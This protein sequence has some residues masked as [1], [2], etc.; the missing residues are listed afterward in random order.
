M[1]KSGIRLHVVAGVALLASSI[2]IGP[3]MAATDTKSF[4]D[5]FD[6]LASSRWYV[7]DGWANGAHQN[8]AWSK[9][10]IS[11][12]GGYL[13]VGFRKEPGADN[14]AYICGE[15]QTRTEFSYGT[16]EARYKTPAGS[17]LN[18]AFFTYIAPPKAAAHDEI[19]FEGLLKDTAKVQTGGFANNKGVKSQTPDLPRP[20]DSDFID[21]AFVWAPGKLDYYVDGKLVHSVT[22]PAQVQTLPQRIY[23]S[24]WGSDT[25]IDWM[26]PFA[27]PAGPL[28]MQV[29]WVAYTAPGDKC[30]FPQSITCSQ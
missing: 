6:S 24:L 3:S 29:D 21:Y 22:D 14:R 13:H 10:E 20:S 17:G 4:F 9:K 8:C 11:A 5:N 7:S 27:E 2:G 19:D 23:F 12:S 18:A 15:V 28:D 30:L 16:Y 1:H 26:G 25:L